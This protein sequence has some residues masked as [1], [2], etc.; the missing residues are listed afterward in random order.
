M[1]PEQ[2]ASWLAATQIEPGVYPGLPT[3]QYF[4]VPAIGKADLDLIARSPR[5][6]WHARLRA[7]AEPRQPTDDMILGSA[8][9]C[10][11]L[12][13]LEFDRRYTVAPK[14]DRRTKVG[15]E[16]WAAFQAANAQRELLD[17]EGM[18]AVTGM[19]ESI[20][21]HRAASY[22]LNGAERETSV[23][24]T[25]PDHGCLMR[26]RPD[27]WG[28]D[29][30]V[31]IKTTGDASAEA[32]QRVAYNMRYHVSAALYLDGV[33]VA[34]GHELVAYLWIVV[35]RD[36]PHAV[37]VYVADAAQIALGRSLYRR[38]LHRLITCRAANEWPGLPDTLSPLGLPRWARPDLT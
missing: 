32:F 7:G 5:H 12:E 36:A 26:A 8:L 21:A 30:L 38:D 13:P 35:E 33:K 28:Q 16:E 29:V 11:V 31:D 15:K 17:A 18:E 6:Y 37:A 20:L 34:T 9:H 19:R 27:A 1:T 2:R 22:F 4:A 24:W 23:F 25:D 10:A 3:D 14:C